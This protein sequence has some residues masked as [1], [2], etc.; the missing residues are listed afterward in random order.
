MVHGQVAEEAE[1]KKK[2]SDALAGSWEINTETRASNLCLVRISRNPPST[3]HRARS[4]RTA[5]R[6]WQGTMVEG[7]SVHRIATQH[8]RRLVGRAYRATSPNGRFA[9]GAQLINGRTFSRCEAQCRLCTVLAWW[10]R[11][12][13]PWPASWGWRGWLWLVLRTPEEPPCRSELRPKLRI[14]RRSTP[15]DRVVKDWWSR[16]LQ[17]LGLKPAGELC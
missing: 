8:T 10:C 16:L 2:R 9:E 17:I 6:S 5:T 1:Q 4:G 3:S 15:V 12:S 11:S 7:H 14:L 13:P